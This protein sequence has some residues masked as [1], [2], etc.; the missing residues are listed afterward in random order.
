MGLAQAWSVALY[1]V[2]GLAVE[3][4]ADVGVGQ[5]RTHLLG[6]PDASL[7]ESK[8]RV[9]A[10][11]RNSEEEWPKQRIVLG[12]SPANLP[13]GGSSYD[14]AIACATLAA[15][16]SIPCERLATTALLGELALDGRVRAIRGV[17]PSLLAARRAGLK[18]AI[19]PVATLPEATLVDGIELHGA[20]TLAEVLTWLRGEPITLHPPPPPTT[21][22]LPSAPDLAD[23]VGQPEARWALEVAAAGA[24][25]L[26]LTGPPGTGKTMLAER[27]PG[28]L[29]PLTREES[30][31]VTAV[32]SV[33]GVL[34]SDYP[35]VASPPFVDV[36]HTTSI[37][38]LIGGGS[39][40]AKPG[41]ASRAHK[42]VL[43]LDEA[44]EFGQ[45]T[46]DA[47]RTALEEGEVRIPRR[48]GIARYPARFQLIL[49]T[50]PCPCAPPKE[51]D[52]ICT[53]M[54]RR[55][56]QSRL[57]GPLLDRVDLRVR[58]R[59][60]TAMANADATPPEPT[61]VVR[62]RVLKARTR[63]A[64][65]WSSH[66]HP[67]QANALVPGPSLRR[68]FALPKPTT[69]LLDRA[70]ALGALT[71]RGADRCLRVAWTLADL[72]EA[73]TP[74]PDHVAAALQFRERRAP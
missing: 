73:D 6:L 39:G 33:A 60:T 31:A 36:H 28:L 72:A 62:A 74:T 56:Y 10:A 64:T 57:S 29:P 8:E 35:L 66:G 18:T 54:V 53:A 25:H 41:A 32:H 26:L 47:L 69:A 61:A 51:T 22:R 27:L 38:A 49:A 71:G 17:L 14:L 55:R 30:L 3:I 48:D 24:H 40:M 21:P 20:Q 50:N 65:R 13:K 42:G 2:D 68:E 5:P 16:G 34:S 37:A 19:V 63:A 58:M 67:W 1:G 12:L 45:K 15:A 59:A 9:K 70:L 43:F 44:C 11:V 52:C 46:I 4:E 23:V 7:H